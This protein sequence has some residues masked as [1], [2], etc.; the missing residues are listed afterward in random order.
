[1]EGHIGQASWVFSSI[2]LKNR[3]WRIRINNSWWFWRWIRKCSKPKK[4]KYIVPLCLCIWVGKKNLHIREKFLVL[5]EEHKNTCSSAR[6]KS[7]NDCNSK[8]NWQSI[9]RVFTWGIL[10]KTNKLG[11]FFKCVYSPDGTKWNYIYDTCWKT[12]TK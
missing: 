10:I 6:L 4:Y 12:M 2:A 9:L 8:N 7:V 5:E 3:Y 11:W 1:M